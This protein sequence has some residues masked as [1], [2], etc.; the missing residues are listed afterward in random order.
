MSNQFQKSIWLVINPRVIIE[1]SLETVDWAKGNDI[2]DADKNQTDTENCTEGC[3]TETRGAD[4]YKSEHCSN[5]SENEVEPKAKSCFKKKKPKRICRMDDNKMLPLWGKYPLRLN[6]FKRV[7]IPEIRES[8][9][10]IQ[11]S[12]MRVDIGLLMQMI[13]RA[14]KANPVMPI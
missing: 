7:A 10:I 11:A 1:S 8:K 13:P 6:Q 5:D 4:W 2:N 14:I 9:P 12:E 3:S